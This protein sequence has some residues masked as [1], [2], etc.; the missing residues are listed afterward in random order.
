STLFP[1]TT[2]FRSAILD[3]R[4][5]YQWF[6]TASQNPNHFSRS[7]TRQD[8][9]QIPLEPNVEYQAHSGHSTEGDLDSIMTPL[10]LSRK[11][12]RYFDSTKIMTKDQVMTILKG[13]M[14]VQDIWTIPSAGGMYSFVPVVIFLKRVEDINPGV[15]VYSPNDYSLYH[16][17][18]G[19]LFHTKGWYERLLDSKELVSS[20]TMIILLASN[21]KKIDRK[22]SNRALRF[23]FI[24]SGHMA[25]NAILLAT[26]K[27]VG[28]LEYG[29]F[30]D[31]VA[32]MIISDEHLT[33]MTCL[34][35]GIELINVE[36][37]SSKP[38]LIYQLE[39]A[40]PL[41]HNSLTNTQRSFQGY[42]AYSIG[43]VARENSSYVGFGSGTTSE[44]AS[45]KAIVESIERG[46]SMN[47]W[48][49]IQSSAEALNKSYFTPNQ[50]WGYHKNVY[51]VSTLKQLY[52]KDILDWVQLTGVKDGNTKYALT[53][54]I[55]YGS[56][57]ALGY[58]NSN[59]IAA[60]VDIH[61]AFSSGFLELIER[62]AFISLYHT[63][64][65]V[66]QVSHHIWPNWLQNQSAQ[67]K[68]IGYTVIVLD[69][70]SDSIPVYLICIYSRDNHPC[71]VS[72]AAAG[73]DYD[74]ILF[75]AFAEAEAMLLSWQNPLEETI[76]ETKVQAFSDHGKLYMDIENLKKLA[77]L[78]SCPVVNTCS[79]NN[80]TWEE[81]INK[82][83]PYFVELTKNDP[84][85]LIKVVKVLSPV[86][87]PMYFGRGFEPINH[88]R[89]KQLGLKWI[90]DYPC[91][92]HFFS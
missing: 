28:N 65:P 5:W 76:E 63:H 9:M 17:R 13:M 6:L 90:T 54:M 82:Y 19:E 72:G 64:R 16:W 60:H 26:E 27:G 69:I 33:A 85:S 79:H 70:T 18:K 37:N 55:F 87:L 35:F 15:Y 39:Q 2:L 49:D 11:S 25:Q 50:I 7:V 74:N 89:V 44:E 83:S 51:Q 41:V 45:I 21:L 57:N 31:C 1:Y 75:K 84:T 67:L 62:D 36:E 4:Q 48:Y 91:F 80:F 86:L 14:K 88:K 58:G 32:E 92:P 66:L 71:F 68:N 43:S 29:G 12:C 78:L 77:W 20:A 10:F 53:E 3:S 81:L 56:G 61:Q 73:F 46:V 23:A 30:D 52:K 8:V 22:Y 38:N 47:N 40:Y 42:L 34:I 24:E 59:G